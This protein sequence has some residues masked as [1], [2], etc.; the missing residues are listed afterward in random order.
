MFY[1]FTMR[2]GIGFSMNERFQRIKGQGIGIIM[3]FGCFRVMIRCINL[4]VFGFIL[5]IMLLRINSPVLLRI[6]SLC[7]VRYNVT[8]Y[9]IRRIMS[10]KRI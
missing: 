5:C 4:S 10:N 8:V 9:G 1:L 3:C 2:Q 6:G 7:C